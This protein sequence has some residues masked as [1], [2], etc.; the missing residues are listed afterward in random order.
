MPTSISSLTSASHALQPAPPAKAADG[1]G[2]SADSGKRPVALNVGGFAFL[3][4]TATLAAVDGSYFCKLAR[5]VAG[6]PSSSGAA[7]F[8][9]D[10]SGKVGAGLW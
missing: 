1:G 10:R 2:S 4:T 5:Q 9:I 7:E 3:T 8:F 6:R